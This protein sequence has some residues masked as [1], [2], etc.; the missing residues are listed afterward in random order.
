MITAFTSVD[1]IPNRPPLSIRMSSFLDAYGTDRPFAR[2]WRTEDG[3]LSVVDGSATVIAGPSEPEELHAFLSL[4]GVNAVLS[5][6]RIY[7]DS[8][9]L[10]VFSKTVR[11]HASP[12]P[13]PDYEV[14]YR[15]FANAFVL[16]AWQD[17]YV[18]ACH[19]V[20]HGAALLA[21]EEHG[22]LFAARRGSQLL[23]T[24]LAVDPAH[25]RQGVASRLLDAVGLPDVSE[26]YAI[27]ESDAA[28]AFYTANGF[29][30]CGEV[31]L[32][33][34]GAEHDS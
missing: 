5:D 16:P 3:A 32:Y 11:D 30:P 20:R 12:S 33:V 31:Y 14:A 23:L 2:F 1:R 9:A 19:R 4:L 7:P 29:T 24:G 8:R 6:K 22:A 28:K 25:R 26:I 34:K 21:Q 18:D 17:W 15:L 27:V 10:S 13:D